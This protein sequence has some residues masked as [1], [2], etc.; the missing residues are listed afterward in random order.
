MVQAISRALAIVRLVA[1]SEDGLRLYELA[2]RMELKRSTVYNLADT[3][4][5][6]GV[7]TKRPDTRYQ[8]GSMIRELS[9]KQCAKQKRR[10]LEAV[11][12]ELHGQYPAATIVYSQMSGSDIV[13]KIHIPPGA[14][15]N[16]QYPDNMQLNP[17]TT[18]CGL[19]YWA[20]LADDTLQGLRHKYPF[21]YWGAD[22]WG[23]ESSWSE[24]VVVARCAGYAE[25]PATPESI[26]KFGIPVFEQGGSLDGVITFSFSE[27][28]QQWNAQRAGIL[29]GLAAAAE[30]IRNGE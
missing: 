4:V 11:L 20:H 26:L 28:K 29:A 8:L 18:V 21:E 6:E 15:E 19:L 1:D 16:V 14:G 3:L 10:H 17:Y 27:N 24:A 30:R 22:S 9:L 13:G 7:L 25:S 12:L 23:L 5:K 2:E